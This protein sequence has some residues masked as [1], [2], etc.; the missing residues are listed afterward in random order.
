MTGSGSGE[1]RVEGIDKLVRT[2]KKAG[3]DISELKKAHTRAGEIVAT[4]AA[5]RAPA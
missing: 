2:L 3:D 5:A 1:I 4:E